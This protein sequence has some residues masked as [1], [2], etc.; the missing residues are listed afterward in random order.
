MVWQPVPQQAGVAHSQPSV[1]GAVA[2]L[3]SEVPALQ[4]YEQVDP[5]QLAADAL[6]VWQTSPQALQSATVLSPE[7]VLSPAQCVCVHVHAP[8]AQV[9]VGWAQ[10]VPFVQVPVALHVCGVLPLHAVCPGA[11]TPLHAPETQVWLVHAEAVP[12]APPLHASTELPTHWLWP[13]AHTPEQLPAL[14]VWLTH[15]T[16]VPQAPPALH[17]CTLLPEHCTAPGVHVPV[18]AP[19]LHAELTQLTALPHCPA[20]VQV[21]TPLPLH[22]V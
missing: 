15:A 4:V 3:Q 5:L 2:L 8:L 21:S 1:S 10:V 13:G 11:H 7:Q 6:V 20:A 18:Q 22:R 17:V 16:G 14:H 12:Q 19:L 9:G